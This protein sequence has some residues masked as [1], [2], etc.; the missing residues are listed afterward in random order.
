[1]IKRIVKMKFRP[2]TI[3]TFLGIFDQS[4]AH[5]RAFDGCRYLELTRDMRDPQIFFTISHWDSPAHL[6]AYRA[7]DL[8]RSTWEETKA[9]FAGKAQAWSTESVSLLP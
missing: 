9:L 6:E 5:I 7:S 2:E 4:S 8:F 3:G 1:M